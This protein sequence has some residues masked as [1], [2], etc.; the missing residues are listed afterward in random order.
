MYDIYKNAKVTGHFG[1][2]RS[3]Y[4]PGKYHEGDDIALAMN[5]PINAILGGTI[6]G[7]KSDPNGYGN[8]VDIDHGNGIVTRYA[9]ANSFNVK[10]GQKVK[11]GEQIGLV[12]SSGRSSGPHLHLEAMING[13]KRNPRELG[14]YM[15]NINVLKPKGTIGTPNVQDIEALANDYAM[16]QVPQAGLQLSPEEQE[17]KNQTL[18]YLLNK[19]NTP[20][21]MPRFSTIQ[22]ILSAE[23]G[24]RMDALGS[25]LNTPA[26]QNIMG[27]LLG[28]VSGGK[29][30]ST[31]SDPYTRLL[32]ADMDN[33]QNQALWAQRMQDKLADE[34]YGTFSQRD[35]AAAKDALE[36]EQMA[37]RAE[38]FEQQMKWNEDK[39]KQDYNLDLQKLNAQIEHNKEMENIAREKIAASGKQEK[40]LQKNIDALNSLNAVQSQ[41]D[42]FSNSFNDV[43]GSKIGALI[44]NAYASKGFGNTA[45]ANFNAQRTLLFNKIARELGG[46]KGVL[47]DQDIKRIEASLPALSDSLS[48]KKAKMQAI[49]N[50][51]DD[52]KSQYG[53]AVSAG[54]ASQMSNNDGWAF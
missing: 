47:S 22:D 1:E 33:R 21:E 28:L 27:S 51:L 8:Y 37:Q 10:P 45:E 53:G 18:S 31:P 50:L 48:Q 42:R 5:T 39:Y 17:A 20:V 38:Q 34:V 13:I 46:E 49:Y 32:Q 29:L 4:K 16:S 12:G 40:Q 52:R 9:H 26:A 35:I 2:K 30:Y 36:R 15:Q 11:E 25:Y 54:M 23:K 24:N 41:M 44:A 7:V 19:I 3:Y 43:R 6:V 14:K